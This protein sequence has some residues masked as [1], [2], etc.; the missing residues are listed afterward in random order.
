MSNSPPAGWYPDP[1]RPTERQRYWDGQRWTSAHAPYAGVGKTGATWSTQASSPPLQGRNP[2]TRL[3]GLVAVGTITL[4]LLFILGGLS[5]RLW[6]L[7]LFGLLAAVTGILYIREDRTRPARYKWAAWSLIPAFVLAIVTTPATG[8]D[9]ETS[10]DQT[11]APATSTSP[12]ISPSSA[13]TTSETPLAAPALFP[14]VDSQA[15]TQSLTTLASIPTRTELPE[16]EYDP[17][18]FGEPW[19]DDVTVDGGHNGCDTRNDI[20]RRDLS[21]VTIQPGSRGCAVLSGTLNDPYTGTSVAAIGDT[22][23]D[24]VIDHVVPL[25]DAWQKGAQA[26]DAAT[27]QNLANDPRNLQAT[28][29]SISVQKADRDSAGWLPP[30]GQYRCTYV[31]RQVEVKA[32]YH[33]WMSPPEHQAI[34]QL[35]IGCGG[36]AP[37]TPAVSEPPAPQPQPTVEQNAP[38]IPP[39]PPVEP[40]PPPPPVEPPPPPPPVDP[41]P[42]PA[43]PVPLPAP[44]PDGGY[45]G[46]CGPNSYI[47]VDGECIPGPVEAPS[48]PSGATARCNDGTYSFSQHRRGTCSG[49]GGVAEWL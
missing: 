34:E 9:P 24:V 4:G 23:D 19:S 10:A 5:E 37:T 14:Q 42:I 8:P 49:H 46:S 22:L 6:A 12:P 27:L 28:A 35:L 18:R 31:A 47:N 48:P 1:E 7:I 29:S 13:P 41:A 38:V 36:V 32:A 44:A 40:T 2:R 16:T 43:E 17:S 11:R 39:P 26:L 21:A 30:H 20:L 15:A 3:G 45:D 25:P 33:L